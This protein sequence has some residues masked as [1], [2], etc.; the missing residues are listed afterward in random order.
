MKFILGLLIGFV[1]GYKLA[2]RET[3]PDAPGKRLV[4]TVTRV[5]TSAVDRARTTIQARMAGDGDASWN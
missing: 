4:D 3:S 2:E 5:G 1:I